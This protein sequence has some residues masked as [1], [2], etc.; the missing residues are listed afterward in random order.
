MAGIPKAFTHVLGFLITVISGLGAN[1]LQQIF[2]KDIVAVYGKNGSLDLNGINSLLKTIVQDK[3]LDP[4][5][6]PHAQCV[7]G[8]DILVHYGLQNLS[9]LT[10]EHLVTVCPALLNQAVLPP[11][12]TEPPVLTDPTELHVWG[13]G[14]LAVTIINLASLLGLA[15]VPV[16]K[17][18][19]FPKV[20]TYFIGLAVGTLFSNAALQ[21][22]P[23]AFG[24]DPKADG[25]VLQAVGI[26]GG[27]YALYFT[28][29]ILRMLLK[30][31]HEHG[32]G[33]SHFLP[34]E[35]VQQNGVIIA[36]D[37]DFSFASGDKASIT[38]DPPVEQGSCRWL[39]GRRLS[40]VKTVAWMISLSDA[41]HNFIDGLAIGASF[42]VSVLNGFSTS[43]AIVC[44]EFPHELGDFIIL[45]N[46]GLS[47]PQA[48][49]FNLLSAMSCY[50]G[51]VLG[52]LLG[53]AFA[54]NI[55]FA[56]AGGMFL[57]IS[58]ADMLPEMN[59]IASE[60]VRSTKDDI[61]FFAIQNAGILT[62]FTLILL[63]TMFCGN[64]S[65]G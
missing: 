50:V 46:A 10:E 57:Y 6:P 32:H 12:S 11:C 28:E 42:T 40:S 17:K 1:S 54:P 9:H 51:L 7:S 44:E 19:Y 52:I 64:I 18:P 60:Q 63:I 24:F 8:E 22:I 58:L 29:K 48:V 62:G 55:I 36:A 23:E 35:S 30:P 31:G 61:V 2:I 33:H 4:N 34:S 59:M 5:I 53:N 21:L 16:T 43:I 38:T 37:S 26:F 25:Y 13:Y 47:I 56:F 65:L 49:F 45:L 20:L 3:P 39:R 27:F 14:F 15:L 41:L